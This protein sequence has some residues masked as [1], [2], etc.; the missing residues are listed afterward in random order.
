MTKSSLLVGQEL[1]DNAI[2]NLSSAKGRKKLVER[3]DWIDLMEGARK[4]NWTILESSLADATTLTRIRNRVVRMNR[5]S[6][7]FEFT[8]RV[9]DDMIL[10]LGRKVYS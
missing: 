1:S 6:R 3:Q 9:V 10:F 8:S 2:N 7:S 4:N 5:Q